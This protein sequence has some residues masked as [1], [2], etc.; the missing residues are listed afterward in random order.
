MPRPYKNHFLDVSQE[1]L[2]YRERKHKNMTEKRNTRIAILYP[3]DYQARQTATVDNNRFALLFRALADLG[4]DAEPAVYHPEFWQEV[5]QQLTHVDGVLVWVNPIQDG[6]DRTILDSM[7]REIAG[8]G[9]FVSAHPDVILKIGTKE[10]LYQT[11][12]IGWG[13]DT[14]LYNSLEQLR[15]ELPM[16]LAAGEAR[17]LKQYRGNGGSG[18]WKVELIENPPHLDAR[19]RVR[20]AERGSID[21]II[22]LAEFFKLCEPYFVDSGKVIDQAYQSRLLEGMIRCYLVHDQVAGF[23]HQAINALYPTPPGGQ[24]SDVLQ[25]GPRLYHPPTLPEFQALKHKLEQEWVP[26]MQQVL[27]IQTDSLPIIW[28]ADFLLGPK[29]ATGED[30]Y[31]LCEI[32]V[33]SVAPFPDSAVPFVAQAAFTRAQTHGSYF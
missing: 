22:S 5:Y 29:D 21:E 9:V 30:T 2:V 4:V 23:G 11:R 17:V 20:H 26:A 12:H 13:C 25:P 31:V 14:H 1:I 28:D 15:Q 19:I 10:V 33:S 27:N 3:G 8:T 24:P 7:L 16:R 18:V 6:H 32:N